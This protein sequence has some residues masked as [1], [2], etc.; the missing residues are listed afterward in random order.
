MP[1]IN[2]SKAKIVNI[3]QIITWKSYT[4]ILEQYIWFGNVFDNVFGIGHRFHLYSKINFVMSELEENY[5]G[6]FQ[7]VEKLKGIF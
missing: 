5:N 6:K 4:G 1:I 7:D 2:C 3:F